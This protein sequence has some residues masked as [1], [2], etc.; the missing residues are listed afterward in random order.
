MRIE[1]KRQILTQELLDGAIPSTTCTL[2]TLAELPPV[3]A[4]LL[5][6]SRSLSKVILRPRPQILPHVRLRGTDL[7]AAPEDVGLG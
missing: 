3:S 6:T 2:N 1:I 5:C 4:S 7:D